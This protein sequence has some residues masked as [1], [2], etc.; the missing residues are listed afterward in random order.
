MD[1]SKFLLTQNFCKKLK[2][3]IEY[4]QLIENQRRLWTNPGFF[5]NPKWNV[6]WQQPAKLSF[7]VVSHREVA[8]A[9]FVAGDHDGTRRRHFQD[10][11]SEAGEEASHA[12]GREDLSGDGQV[13][14]ET[15]EIGF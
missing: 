9:V 2:I 3:L 10:P 8:L 1:I 13:G 14:S 5:S 11:R 7:A 6:F 15:V 4:Q 12:F